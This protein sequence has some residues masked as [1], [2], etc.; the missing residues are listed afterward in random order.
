MPDETLREM[1]PPILSVHLEIQD[2]NTLTRRITSLSNN[3]PLLLPDVVHWY[4]SLHQS[5]CFGSILIS[6]HR[7]SN[8]GTTLMVALL[9][10]WGPLEITV[11]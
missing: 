4:D 7:T 3:L 5:R 10:V 8:V 2:L 9:I 1:P 6:Y 11:L